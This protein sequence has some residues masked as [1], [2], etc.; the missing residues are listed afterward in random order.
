MMITVTLMQKQSGMK[1]KVIKNEQE[2]EKACER[3]YSLM[4]QSESMVEPGSREGEEMELLSLLI[5][6]YE[7]KRYRM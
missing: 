7:D 1:N 5:E 3:F 2:Y 6:V 4:H